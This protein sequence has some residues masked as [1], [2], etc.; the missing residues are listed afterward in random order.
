MSTLVLRKTSNV[1]SSIEDGFRYSVMYREK[2]QMS[3]L[4]KRKIEENLGSQI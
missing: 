4:I 1:D 2:P 3:T